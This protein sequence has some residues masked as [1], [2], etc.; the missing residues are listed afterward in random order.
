MRLPSA[1]FLILCA[2]TPA[3]ASGGLSCEAKGRNASL[4]FD[5]G[6]TRGMGGPLFSFSGRVQIATKAVEADLRKVSLGLGN[7]AQYWLD[8]KELRLVLYRER[9]GDQPHGY[10]EIIV[11]ATG[12]GDEGTYRGTFA[13]TA[14]DTSG[15][16]ERTHAAEGRVTCFVE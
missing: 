9:E 5:G 3:L 2:A 10:V 14:Y 8:A 11:L 13:L 15:N 7:V 12:G 1:I 4:R 16:R 6:V